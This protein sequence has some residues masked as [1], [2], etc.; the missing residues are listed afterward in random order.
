MI[1]FEKPQKEKRNKM[2]TKNLSEI[3]YIRCSIEIE[4]YSGLGSLIGIEKYGEFLATF[5]CP[6]NYIAS[7]LPLASCKSLVVLDLDGNKN[8]K[9]LKGIED[10]SSLV[11]LDL[12][13]C[14]IESLLPLRKLVKLQE[15]S[16]S[17]ALF[18]SFVGLQDL[19]ELYYLQCRQNPNLNSMKGLPGNRFMCNQG[20]LHFHD[21]H[22]YKIYNTYNSKTWNLRECCEIG[23]TKK[24]KILKEQL[25]FSY[26]SWIFHDKFSLIKLYDYF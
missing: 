23:G 17:C 6:D 10:L 22:L 18:S 21:S 5:K 1:I 3:E 20:Q 11:V 16:C 8:L 15:L 13:R 24:F 19:C 25:I 14:N 12:S 9:S 26:F 7:L 4:S 2:K